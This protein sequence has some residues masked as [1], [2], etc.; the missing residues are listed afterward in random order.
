MRVLRWLGVTQSSVCVYIY[1][2]IYTHTHTTLC[3]YVYI[4]TFFKK[5]QRNRSHRIINLFLYGITPNSGL[6][7]P[8]IL[9]IYIHTR[10]TFGHTQPSRYS[11]IHMP[12]Y[13]H[14]HIYVHYTNIHIYSYGHVCTHAYALMHLNMCTQ[15]QK[16]IEC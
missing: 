1:I 13:I 10:T 9:Y 2:Y 8:R 6:T 7:G 16:S 11:H 4:Y 12:L 14:I 5:K 15:E 3:V